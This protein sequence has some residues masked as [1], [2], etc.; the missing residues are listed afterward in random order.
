MKKFGRGMLLVVAA[1]V[2]VPASAQAQSDADT[3]RT[4]RIGPAKLGAYTVT[5]EA[6]NASRNVFV[7]LTRRS[8][9]SR[10]LHTYTLKGSVSL[11]GSGDDSRATLFA[12]MGSAGAIDMTFEAL[13]PATT[14][15]VPSG[16]D[17]TPGSTRRGQVKGKF[18][19]R[20][21]RRYF[22]TLRI[23]RAGATYGRP[24]TYGCVNSPQARGTFLQATRKVGGSRHLLDA[25]Q[26]GRR[27]AVL[28]SVRRARE[29][30]QIEVRGRGRALTA[31]GDL[32]SG[33]LD[34][35][36]PFLKGSAVFQRGRLTGDL[37][38]KFD[39]LGT[40]RFPATRDAALGRG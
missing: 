8:G 40:W 2:G 18:S 5:V 26:S 20:L 14:D 16:C 7:N 31:A 29:F 25:Q 39:F 17:G 15:P 32:A 11:S 6:D 19:L 3:A 30:H 27:F 35:P 36:G 4:L 37:A 21:D 13:R 28:Y 38:A 34:G 9:A 10:Q 23:T 33:R 22:G 24:A 1:L 12:D